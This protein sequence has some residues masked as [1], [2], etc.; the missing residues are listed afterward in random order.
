MNGRYLSTAP[1]PLILLLAISLPIEPAV[2]GFHPSGDE[3][4]LQELTH[5]SERSI[6]A[7]HRFD[8]LLAD[9]LSAAMLEVYPGHYLSHFSRANY[10]WWLLIT[11]PAGSMAVAAFDDHLRHARQLLDDAVPVRAGDI[12]ALQLFHAAIV[13]ALSARHD[14]MEGHSLR[15]AASGRQAVRY[16]GS[17]SGREDEH[18][19]LFLTMGLYNYMVEA[20]S[21]RYPLFRLYRLFYPRGDKKLGISQLERAAHSGE[22][23]WAT[24]ARYFLMRIWLDMEEEPDRAL[25]YA[26]QLSAAYPENLIYQYY[27]LEAMRLAGSGTE[28]LER[29]REE[30]RSVMESLFSLTPEQRAY[31]RELFE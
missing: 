12:S 23:V 24:E 7:L 8:F 22:Q 18:S 1:V 25:V 9:S 4:G 27:H 26:R 13:Y 19:G 31:F 20:A 14:A 5:L 15:A 16:I 17:A 2:S 30:V 29:R 3:A 21:E 28:E 10:L 11:H 6:E